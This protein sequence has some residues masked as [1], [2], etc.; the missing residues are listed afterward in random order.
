MAG[1]YLTLRG[2]PIL[3]YGEEI[4]MENNDP[5]RKEDV[6]D[7]IG[8]LGWPAEKGRDGERTPM[9]W[10]GGPNGGFTNGGPW[11][12]VPASAATHNVA[13]ESK[14]PNSILQFYKHLL[15]L[16]HQKRPL[17]DGDYI[18]LNQ[19]DP[20][21]LSYL[22][23]YKDRAVLVVL[24][25]SSAAQKASFRLAAQGFPSPKVQ[26]LLSTAASATTGLSGI[27][28]EPFG[29]YIAEISK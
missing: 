5:K 19:D 12:P 18:P 20:N 10:S 25:M 14:D 26:E 1:L 17:L 4:G 15:A 27:S 23:R 13:T 11:L 22:R 29:V 21:V 3:Y 24:N 7:P 6:K 8:K 9:Q 2:T 16:R 28:L